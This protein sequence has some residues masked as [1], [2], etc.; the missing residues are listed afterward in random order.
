MTSRKAKIKHTVIAALL[1]AS[2]PYMAASPAYAGGAADNPANWPEYI[3]VMPGEK[4][5]AIQD[6]AGGNLIVTEIP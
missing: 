3:N 6:S 2:V 5:S 1:A 4:V